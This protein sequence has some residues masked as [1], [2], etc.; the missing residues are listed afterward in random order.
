MNDL[1]G[2]RC[3]LLSEKPR[4]PNTKPHGPNALPITARWNVV[5]VRQFRVGMRSGR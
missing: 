4:G 2:L 1:P 5:C 3:R